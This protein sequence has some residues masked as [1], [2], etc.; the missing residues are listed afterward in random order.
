MLCYAVLR[1]NQSPLQ[2]KDTETDCEE[3][4]SFSL[5]SLST[6][7]AD[8]QLT[9]FLCFF[10]YKIPENPTNPA[11]P[12]PSKKATLDRLFPGEGSFVWKLVKWFRCLTV[13][14]PLHASPQPCFTSVAAI[15][16]WRSIRSVKWKGTGDEIVAP[17][18]N[19][20]Q[21]IFRMR[22]N[23]LSNQNNMAN[24]L[25]SY[26][27][28]RKMFWLWSATLYHDTRLYR[29]YSY[30]IAVGSHLFWTVCDARWPCL[31]VSQFS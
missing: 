18:V 9:L 15:F 11:S 2:R 20:R 31:I 7:V 30:S 8:V 23:C 4:F 16:I 1:Q 10:P 19:K 26:R 3:H 13:P 24:E 5:H 27:L 17:P 12:K 22:S 6:L 25:R 21:F 14:V 28:E 29:G